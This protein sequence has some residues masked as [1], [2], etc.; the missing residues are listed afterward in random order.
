MKLMVIVNKTTPFHVKTLPRYTSMVTFG[1]LFKRVKRLLRRKRNRGIVVIGVFVVALFIAA[2]YSNAMVKT[3]DQAAYA[4][5][6]TT[7]ADGESNGNYNAYFKNASNTSLK[8]TDMTIGDVLAWQKQYVTAGNA[9]NAVGRYQIIEPTLKSLV[10]ELNIPQSAV[11]NEQLQDKLA[12]ALMERRG[13]KDYVAD[14][15][16]AEQFAANL[17]KEWAALPNVTGERPTESYYAGDGLNESRISVEE[18]TQA[19]K[20]FRAAVK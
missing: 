10:A 6:L 1:I 18:I 15:L 20:E 16:S 2:A 13:S 5:L 3:I 11:F 8:F 4:S 7:I 9:S 12:I 14:K 19:V 17:A